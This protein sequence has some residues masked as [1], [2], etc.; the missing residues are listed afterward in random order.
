M[1]AFPSTDPAIIRIA[2][3]MENVAEKVGRIEKGVEKIHGDMDEMRKENG[4]G[5]LK[6]AVM[7][8]RVKSLEATRTFLITAVV[9]EALTIIGSIVVWLVTKGGAP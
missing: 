1:S 3:A 8:N 9:T 6:I 7:E 4:D 2:S 5:K